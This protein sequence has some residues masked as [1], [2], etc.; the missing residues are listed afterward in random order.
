[1][2]IASTD[3]GVTLTESGG[4]S[5]R[6]TISVNH[7]NPLPGSDTWKT[8]DAGALGAAGGAVSSWGTSDARLTGPGGANSIILDGF[9]KGTAAGDSGTGS[10][11]VD[12]GTF[13]EGSLNWSCTAVS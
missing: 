12:D 9:T 5:A 1:M 7:L 8:L 11:N 4:V 6:I 10:K 13:P 3:Y 2:G